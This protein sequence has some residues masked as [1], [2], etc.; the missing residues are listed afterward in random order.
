MKTV[1]RKRTDCS[2]CKL[3]RICD[4]NR[5]NR[6]GHCKHFTQCIALGQFIENIVARKEKEH[7]D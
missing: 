1:M 5:H 3:E 6:K 4:K 2:K 7:D